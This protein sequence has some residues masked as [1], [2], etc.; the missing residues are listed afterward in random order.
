[1]ATMLLAA[2]ATGTSD[3][4][5]RQTQMPSSAPTTPSAGSTAP[6]AGPSAGSTTGSASTPAPSRGVD[7]DTIATCV[8]GEWLMADEDAYG[9]EPMLGERDDDVVAW[10]QQFDDFTEVWGHLDRPGRLTVGFTGDDVA[11]RQDALREAFPGDDAAAIGVPFTPSELSD[12]QARVHDQFPALVDSSSAGVHTGRVE[13]DL[14]VPALLERS[15]EEVVADLSTAFPGEPLCVRVPEDLP[16][17]GPQPD[18]GDG[19]RLLASAKDAGEAYTTAIAT[20]PSSWGDVWSTTMGDVP[21]PEVDFDTEVV[22]QFGDVYGSSCDHL[23]LDDV[24]VASD[25]VH[26]DRVVLDGPACTADA[27]PWSWFVAVDR[28]ALPNPPFTLQLEEEIQAPGVANQVTQ[29]TE[30]TLAGSD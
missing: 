23:R 26:M 30:E 11:D 19:W 3:G 27:N 13:V 22:I 21:L 4:A 7:G 16:T 5:D 20:D 9:S 12:L 8:D 10:A 15:V 25:V 24:V 2:C 29:V 18:G 1:M 14:A 17:A 6:N 28:D